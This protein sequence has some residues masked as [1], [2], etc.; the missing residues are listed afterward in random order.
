M[1]FLSLPTRK[2]QHMC[3]KSIIDNLFLTSFLRAVNSFF[4]LKMIDIFSLISC[5]NNC[6]W[7]SLYVLKKLRL[8]LATLKLSN[9]G[10][11]LFCWQDCKKS[12]SASLFDILKS[13]FS[14]LHICLTISSLQ[15]NRMTF[16]IDLS[17]GNLNHTI[18]RNTND[19]TLI[20]I[21]QSIKPTYAKCCIYNV[22]KYMKNIYLD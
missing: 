22:K 19:K 11:R 7:H 15:Q 17:D 9:F 5:F 16:A 20:I 10:I 12:K 14:N 4:C 2:R 1:I 6:L 13:N 18:K 8:L 21:L 3:A